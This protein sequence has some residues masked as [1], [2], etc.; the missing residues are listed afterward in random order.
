M[1]RVV[2]DS[3]VLVSAFWTESGKAARVLRMFIEGKLLLIYSQDILTEY[4][5][6]LSRPKLQ[7]K[8]VRIG[9]LVNHIRKN[10][11]NVNPPF[12]DIAFVDESDRKF[13]DAA[14]TYNAILIT[15]NLKHYPN[16]PF[17]MTVSDFLED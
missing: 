2:F 13:Y 3:N 10:G 14:K 4:K 9:E 1:K 7:F 5:T 15:G 16:E 17:I 8:R 6:V 12:S 11:V